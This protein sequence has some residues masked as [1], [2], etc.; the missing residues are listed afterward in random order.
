MA[1]NV[2][3]IHVNDAPII[4]LN[5]MSITERGNASMLGMLQ[6][7]DPDNTNA[8]L[9]FHVVS[10]VH[11][12]FSNKTFTQQDIDNGAIF[13][14]T[15]RTDDMPGF[16]VYVED[17]TLRSPNST[18]EVNFTLINDPPT[19]ILNELEITEGGTY[20][21]WHHLIATD[22]DNSPFTLQW[23]PISITA[24]SF[25]HEPWEQ[26]DVDN[27]LIV[28]THDGSETPP[29]YTLELFDQLTRINSTVHLIKFTKIN[30]APNITHNAITIAERATVNLQ[31]NVVV[32]DPD[33]NAS[34]IPVT[35][36][37]K[38]GCTFK[39]VSF[40]AGDINK[41]LV[42][43]TDL[44]DEAPPSFT[45]Q[46][47]DGWLYSTLSTAIV[48]YIPINDPPTLVLNQFSLREQLPD[49]SPANTWLSVSN[50]L[51]TDPDTADAN[52]VFTVAGLNVGSFFTWDNTDIENPFIVYL[53]QFTMQQVRERRI[54][55][56]SDTS[57]TVPSYTL[58]VSD[59]EFTV[60]KQSNVNYIRVN[61]APTIAINAFT[62]YQYQNLPI[63][64]SMLLATDSDNTDVQ[65]TFRVL[66]EQNGH[67]TVSGASLR[68]FTQDD[69][70]R[71][72]V[73]FVHE[74]AEAAPNFTIRVSDL[75]PLRS[76]VSVPV[77]TYINVNDPPAIENNVMVVYEGDSY[78][79]TNHMV[80]ATDP[81][82]GTVLTIT[83]IA[84]VHCNFTKAGAIVPSFT[85]AEID[86][87]E[88]VF[89]HDGGEVPPSFNITATDGILTTKSTPVIILF[90]RIDDHPH[91]TANMITISE[92]G[93][94]TLDSTMLNTGDADNTTAQ[95]TYTVVVVNGH[96]VNANPS[97]SANPAATFTQDDV[98]SGYVSLVHYGG[99]EAP[100]YNVTV[101]D[102]IL[103]DSGVARVFFSNVNDSPSIVA[104]AFTIYEAQTLVIS[105]A[106][107]DAADPD[108]T[109]DQLTYTFTVTNVDV[110]SAST[111]A[112]IAAFTQADVNNGQVAIKHNGGEFAPTMTVAVSDGSLT[113]T[114]EMVITF[115]NVNDPPHITANTLTIGEAQTVKLNWTM[116][117]STDP[118]NTTLQLTYT[119]ARLNGD[120][121]NP[122]TFA[123][124][125]RFTQ[126]DV[127]AGNVAF[128]HNGGEDAPKYN[129]TLSDGYLTAFSPAAITF[130]NINDPPVLTVGMLVIR[131]GDNVP[132][133]S[134]ILNTADP[135][136]ATDELTYTV[137]PVNGEF[138]ERGVGA[139]TTFTQADINSG[140]ISFVHNGGEAA[141]QYNVTV[142]DGLATDS[143]VGRV[144]FTNVNDP[145]SLVVGILV[146][147]E[148]E[149]VPVTADVL[150]ATDVDN[151]AA[152]LRYTVTTVNA[153][154]LNATTLA[155]ITTFSQADVD[156]GHVVFKHNAGEAAP[157]YTV[158]LTDG[159]V[160]IQE[161]GIV[162]FFSINDPPVITVNTMT[163]NEGDTIP[164]T[165]SILNTADPD[166]TTDELTYT[167][168]PVN[169]EFFERGVGAVT[170]FTQADINSG[171]ISFVHNG[172]EAAPQY[173]VTVSDG[174]A[175]DFGAANIHFHNLN[176]RPVISHNLISL[177]QG[178]QITLS[179][180][181]LVA[182]DPD[183][184]ESLLIFHV[185]SVT[186][187]YFTLGGSVVRWFYQANVTR[188]RVV[189]A[190]DGSTPLA[191]A[192]I[193][194]PD[195]GIGRG[196]P[197][198][199]T[200][201]YVATPTIGSPIAQQQGCC[202]TG[203]GLDYS[204]TFAPNTF[205]SVETLTYTVSG[206]PAWLS[207]N[208]T[209]RTFSGEPTA[210]PERFQVNVTA[211]TGTV[212]C[213]QQQS[214]F[215]TACPIGSY[216]PPADSGL[217]CAQMICPMGYTDH[218][219]NPSTECV[220]CG[221][222]HAI[223]FEGASGDCYD[224]ACEPGKFDHDQNAV[225]PC[226]PV[227][228][229]F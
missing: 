136:N 56:H 37:S 200:V 84:P 94:V 85:Q 52:L 76:A 87:L 217:T 44:D 115:R 40:T 139:V 23:T 108:N 143:A 128:R 121:I 11:G 141:P 114:A 2:T 57:E 83:V 55:F 134:S 165:A 175:T 159:T 148:G 133:S 123:V 39:P 193:I 54:Y 160:T 31:G 186:N 169:G 105:Q 110:I 220:R 32:Y 124:L 144:S 88:I 93:T 154:F 53:T 46:A 215:I 20:N 177:C 157:E 189:F 92:S 185:D 221:A 138:F 145:P 140:L 90:R 71:G 4:V 164:I 12:H 218:D 173:N 17:G 170:T 147:H 199:A 195:D 122:A 194:A 74:G 190:H 61:D 98:N 33:T 116:L 34:H 111:L 181:N 156:G 178:G 125:T 16:T 14:F 89:T 7:Y 211:T 41:G 70:N 26:I 205:V 201:T 210:A 65:L 192:Y 22:P 15:D 132:I 1:A 174:L 226:V 120:F 129:L 135:D 43:V 95:L 42:T 10:E 222:G 109:P 214:F 126:A 142:S 27:Q 9:V 50:I 162:S 206:L 223:P 13:F 38:T 196:T 75:E 59:G 179:A 150:A 184:T 5:K 161:S 130:Y 68:T 149:T 35:V 172:G 97:A 227:H 228:R 96:F 187:G 21:L 60:S 209:T 51:A 18:A 216:V 163:L 107:L 137:V 47:Y 219:S 106:M 225:S 49:G 155:V 30:D 113:A 25:N 77:I 213:I 63:D 207:F 168:V 229:G 28:F 153:Q 67:F 69:V 152:Q 103:T 62:I 6:A 81:D 212:S 72:L 80:E 8:E 166:N 146:L 176:D 167:V 101:S 208:S 188:G 29:S 86:A 82:P 73:H 64:V 204:F 79:I 102:G 224:Y 182:T 58:W 171:L 24:G 112:A 118:D 78:P 158:S 198:A 202:S 117:N 183:N 48:T 191:P 119:F 99:E 100:Q 19:I 66:W 151:T 131:E 203:V 127:N 36:V 45:L 197:V 104:N 180:A 3:L 91:I